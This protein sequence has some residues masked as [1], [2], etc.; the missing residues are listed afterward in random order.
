[1]NDIDH[2]VSQLQFMG[3]IMSAGGHLKSKESME[4]LHAA[5]VEILWLRADNHRKEDAINH[6]LNAVSARVAP[7]LMAAAVYEAERAL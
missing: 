7:D 3:D 4:T 2:L 1:M 5:W 6:L